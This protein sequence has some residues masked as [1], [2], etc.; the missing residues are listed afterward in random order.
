MSNFS[1]NQINQKGNILYKGYKKNT[2][3][4][5]YIIKP[6]KYGD[7]N[8]SSLEGKLSFKGLNNLTEK[9]KIL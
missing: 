2:I 8:I 6:L 4:F 1:V 9:N 3:P 5:K 7:S